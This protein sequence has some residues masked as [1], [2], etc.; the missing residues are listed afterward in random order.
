VAQLAFLHFI[1]ESLFALRDGASG[2]NC[3]SS[4]CFNC[5]F[6]EHRKVEKGAASVAHGVV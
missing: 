1:P 5:F 4:C 3:A 6:V 2:G